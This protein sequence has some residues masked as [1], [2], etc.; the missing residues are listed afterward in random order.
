MGRLHLVPWRL[1]F[2]LCAVLLFTGCES[3]RAAAGNPIKDRTVYGPRGETNCPGPADDVVVTKVDAEL[4][5]T[6]PQLTQSINVGAAAET[7][8]KEV[9]PHLSPEV[10]AVLVAVALMC[11]QYAA[12]LLEPAAY[13]KFYADAASK[14]AGLPP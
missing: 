3:L 5:A 6:L 4:K 14:I 9:R 2:V 12:G 1:L 13:Q 8:Y 10:N 7:V 11:R